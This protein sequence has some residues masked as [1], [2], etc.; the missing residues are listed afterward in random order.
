MLENLEREQNPAE[1]EKVDTLQKVEAES[2]PKEKNLTLG[3][4]YTQE[5]YSKAQTTWEKANTL[6]KAETKKA[7]WIGVI[8]VDEYGWGWLWEN[9]E[10]KCLGRNRD[11]R[12]C[13]PGLCLG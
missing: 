2:L 6:S 3:K 13:Y 7:E 8:Y 10:N 12:K 1:S 5:Q 4:T 9:G 11:W